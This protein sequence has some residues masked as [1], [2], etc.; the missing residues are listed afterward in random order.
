MVSLFDENNLEGVLGIMVPIVAIIGGISLAFGM[1]YLRSR[2][3][4]ELI[5]RGVDITKLDN[6]Q[7]YLDYFQRNGDHRGRR[8]SPLRRGLVALG[9]GA[10][11]LCAYYVSPMILPDGDHTVIYFGF[12]G[13]FVGMGLILSFLLERNEPLDQK[14]SNSQ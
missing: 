12:V 6:T 11:L 9:A 8:R 4:I 10:G 14:N 3:R 1:S 5:S 7:K 2:E 13:V